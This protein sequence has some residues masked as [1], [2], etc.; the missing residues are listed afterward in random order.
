MDPLDLLGDLP[1]GA[2]GQSEPSGSLPASTPKGIK[3][4]R[5]LLANV[6]KISQASSPTSSGAPPA[7]SQSMSGA[8]T[9]RQVQ[10]D[11]SCLGCGRGR[12]TCLSFY[13]PGG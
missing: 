9:P 10:E 5:G 8:G 1:G 3:R 4:R 11:E 2:A 12:N 13:E 7:G 6:D